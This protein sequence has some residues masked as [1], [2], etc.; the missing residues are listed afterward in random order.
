MKKLFPLVVLAGG[1]G[2]R[3]SECIPE[4][5]KPLVNIEGKPLMMHS[6]PILVKT[7]DINL[8]IYRIAHKADVFA[9]EFNQGNLN[10]YVPTTMSIGHVFDGPIG[11]MVQ[12]ISLIDA[13]VIVFVAGD[14]FFDGV[15]FQEALQF[16]RSH[17]AGLTVTVAQSPPTKRPSTLSVNQQHILTDYTRKSLTTS[18]DLINAGLYFV[19]RTAVDW[20]VQD[21]YLWQ[22]NLTKPEQYKEDNL[23]K[24]ILNK[25]ER[26]L[27]FKLTG[28]VVNVNSNDELQ[29][30]TQLSHTKSYI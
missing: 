4:M 8:V 7:L 25:P 18:N 17:Q 3:M 23:W 15:N 21:Y 2:S 11:A 20:L 12:L 29:F 30:A 1:A 14:A 9:R 16:H 13:E 26:A 27:L 19:N 5:P 28:Q 6:L 10:L 22:Q 24:L